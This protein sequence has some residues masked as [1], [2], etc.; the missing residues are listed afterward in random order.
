MGTPLLKEI[1]QNWQKYEPDEDI[2]VP[3][4]IDVTLDTIV[5][6]LPFD[7][8][9]PRMFEGLEYVLSFEQVGDAIVGLE[10]QLRRETSAEERLAAVLHYARHD[11][12]IDPQ[13]LPV[14]GLR[15]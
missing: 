15:E 2:Y 14:G 7:R 1:L 6:I 3:S 13:H 8:H 10:A 4:G 12:F 11:A 5:T 9:R